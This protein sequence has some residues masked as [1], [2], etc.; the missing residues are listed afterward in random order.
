[1]TKEI[2]II[3]SGYM[4][5]QISA[6]YYCLGYKVNI[7]YNQNKNEKN[8]KKNIILLKRKFPIH[9]D[10]KISFHEKIN[11][12]KIP[13]I[14]C[15]SEEYKKKVELFSIIFDQ[16]DTNI[17]SNTS[18]IPISNINNKI[19]ILHFMNPIFLKIVEVCKNN[20]DNAG[21]KIISDLVEKN[22]LVLDLPHGNHG[23][24]NKIVFSEISNFFEL[25]EKEN[26]DKNALLEVMKK[27][28]GYDILNLIDIIGSDISLNIIKNFINNKILKYEP[29]FFKDLI[30]REIYGKK[31]NTSVVSFF[32]SDEYPR[33]K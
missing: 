1:M 4:G 18:S 25:I 16:Y 10:G 21:N 12:K 7:F 20:V 11:I 14:E 13:T 30:N 15:V 17:F 22:F 33:K 27:L 3:G 26:F 8:L 29:Y 31:N 6:L 23:A 28:K 24:V 2:N 32:K 9:C 5:S 19:S